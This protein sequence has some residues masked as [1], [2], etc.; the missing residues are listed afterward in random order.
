[1]SVSMS[2]AAKSDVGT[3]LSPR[4]R[5]AGSFWKHSEAPAR[6]SES[7][8]EQRTHVNPALWAHHAR[9]GASHR[10]KRMFTWLGGPLR[11]PGAGPGELEHLPLQHQPLLWWAGISCQHPCPGHCFWGTATLR[12]PPQLTWAGGKHPLG[13]QELTNT[14]PPLPLLLSTNLDFNCKAGSEAPW[15]QPGPML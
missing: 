11:D 12:C 6:V 10:V 2:E 9:R 3:K 7:P 15:M 13:K 1:M 4:G 8:Q 5:A 14:P